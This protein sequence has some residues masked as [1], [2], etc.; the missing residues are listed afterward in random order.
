MLGRLIRIL[1]LSAAALTLTPPLSAVAKPAAVAAQRSTQRLTASDLLARQAVAVA[2][3]ADAYTALPQQQRGRSMPF[4]KGL[5]DLANAYRDVA[6]A[7]KAHDNRKMGA[8]LPKVAT[9][10]AKLNSAFQMSGVRDP[11][12]KN[13][14]KSLDGLW[15]IYLKVVDV[16]KPPRAAAKAKASARKI[17]ELRKALMR[18]TADRKLDARERAR[19]A[20][21]LALVRQA[22]AASRELDQLWYANMLMAEA[23]GY[24]AGLYEYYTAYDS[25][26]AEYY[27][28]GW[29]EFSSETRY[30]YSESISYYEEYSWSSY[31]QTVEV[32]ESYDFGMSEQ[33]MSSA[34]IEVESADSFISDEAVELYQDSD[35]REALDTIETR[36]ADDEVVNPEEDAPEDQVAPDKDGSDNEDI[37]GDDDGSDDQ[38][39]SGDDGGSDDEDLSGDD[40]GSDDKDLSGDDGGSDDEDLSGDDSGGGEDYSGDDSGG[41]EDYSGDDSG[42]GED[43]SSDDSGGGEDYSGE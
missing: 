5:L 15:K 28:D 32:R 25:D 2:V 18:Q 27:R 4:L 11:K 17:S 30:F 19:R 36:I 12:I 23:Y 38:D 26:Y 13:S 1:M 10:L 37:S 33:E 8:A 14:L 21:L 35:E 39:L 22:E 24:Y 41:G 20:Q 7:S 31:E 42:G 43:Y 3:I 16:G 29:D 40:G 6:T 9:S 34:M